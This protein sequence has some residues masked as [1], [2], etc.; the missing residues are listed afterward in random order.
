MHND[1]SKA[2]GISANKL[3]SQ[4]DQPIPEQGSILHLRPLFRSGPFS[5]A[6]EQLIRNE[7]VVGSNPMRGSLEQQALQRKL[8]GLLF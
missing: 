2:G 1:R 4:Y 3:R 7:Q 6:V 5:S 8:G